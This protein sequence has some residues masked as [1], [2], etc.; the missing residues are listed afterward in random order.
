MK[1][2]LKIAIAYY[3]FLQIGGELHDRLVN[4]KLYKYKTKQVLNRSAQHLEEVLNGWFDNIKE[5]ELQKLFFA[6]TKLSEVMLEA[7]EEKDIQELTQLLTEY[8]SGALQ[9]ITTKELAE[10]VKGETPSK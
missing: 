2:E 3:A 5:E 9:I 8:Q 6:S 1:K 4:T 7:I 10:A